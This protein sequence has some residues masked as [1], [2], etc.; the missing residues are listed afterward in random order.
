[1]RLVSSMSTAFAQRWTRGFASL[2]NRRARPD[3]LCLQETRAE[4]H[5]LDLSWVDE[6]SYHQTWNP[7]VKKG[8]SGTAIWSKVLPRKTGLGMGDEKHDQEG[9]VITAT[10][11]DFHLVTVYT[12]N[13]QR[14]LARLDYRQAWD[15]DFL[16][17]VQRLNR[18]KPVIFCGDVN[19]A[20]Q[21]IDL[22][23]PKSNRKN[24]GFSDE[25]R[26]AW[27][28]WSRRDLSTPSAI[29]TP[30]L[31]NT[32]GGRCAVTPVSETSDGDWTIFGWPKSLQIG[33]PVRDCATM[34]LDRTTVPLN[35]T[36]DYQSS[37]LKW[38]VRKLVSWR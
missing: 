14:G 17:Y 1:M 16:A 35:W 30:V 15:A 21:E 8:Y 18:R 34:S 7:A 36:F 28:A 32:H 12:P 19:C 24:A 25:E 22:A 4:P 38:P 37:Q 9:R 20:H 27:T 2:S 11:D 10:Y 6:L 31:G 13:A 23:N 26:R 33:W 29:L 5:Q 3:V